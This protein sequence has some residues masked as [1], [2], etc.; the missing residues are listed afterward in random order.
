MAK[1]E[2]RAQVRSAFAGIV[3]LAVIAVA[4]AVTSQAQAGHFLPVKS[5]KMA[6]NDV[7]TLQVNDDLR[8][9]S[10][11]I[12]RVSSIDYNDGEAIVTG[13]L[14]SGSPPIYRNASAQVL[15]VSPLAL[16][17]VNL[18][19][20]T[21][22]A[23]PLP[24]GAVIPAKQDI[25]S[26]DLQDVLEV[27]DPKTR[28][29]ATSTLREVGFGLAGHGQDL[30]QF[31]GSAPDLLHDLGTTS[32]T[33][34]SPDFDLPGLMDSVDQLSS[35]LDSRQAQLRSL[36][37][38]AGT[39]MAA[40]GVDQGQPLES[41]LRT[42]P[43]ALHDLRG[44]LASLKAPL[45][46]LQTA[47][48]T[49]KPGADD[50]GK[51]VPDLRGT[52]REGVPVLGKVPGVADKATPAVGDLKDTFSDL[53]PLTPKVADLLNDLDTPL[54]VL[55]P[56]GADIGQFFF[57]G[58]S[59][60]SEGPAPGIRYARLDVAIEPQEATGGIYKSAMYPRDEYPKPGQAD[61]DQS[62]NLVPAGIVPALPSGGNR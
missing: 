15:S 35:R 37:D 14:I 32:G 48:E 23:G 62:H 24:D 4:V 20:G 13:E 45:G 55:A 5:V 36:I 60:V 25:D 6:F 61:K 50:L 27:L 26:S 18:D 17:Y 1:P 12:G 2:A 58:H 59:F 39:T 49:I 31:V 57:R 16:K 21:P 7:H 8:V 42:A 38:T 52:F 30:N 46:D 29:A 33:L 10:S 3:V 51:T 53:R 9:Y 22:D 56:Y 11:R 43:P 28:A 44:A 41:T 34:A 47:M 40:L 54:T 19:P